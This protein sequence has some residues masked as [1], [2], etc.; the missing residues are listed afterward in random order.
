[1]STTSQ[2]PSQRF[3]QGV[4]IILSALLAGLLIAAG[5]KGEAMSGTVS[6][7][8]GGATIS[9][10]T[11]LDTSQGW[12][13]TLRMILLDVQTT[14][15]PNIISFLQGPDS[16]VPIETGYLKSTPIIHFSPDAS[17]IVLEWPVMYAGYLWEMEPKGSSVVSVSGK[18]RH[19]RDT[20]INWSQWAI[21]NVGPMLAEGFAQV[22][23]SY[24]IDAE[25]TY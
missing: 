19:G 24:G 11:G 14:I 18:Q 21:D 2:D 8:S 9:F 20:Y 25:V 4:G 22:A 6:T 13:K 17:E 15:F 3:I 23:R 12:S 16:K 7:D 5:G 10:Q 1:M